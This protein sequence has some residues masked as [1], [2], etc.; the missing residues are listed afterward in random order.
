MFSLEAKSGED[1][2]VNGSEAEIE[3]AFEFAG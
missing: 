1:L 3:N 2:E